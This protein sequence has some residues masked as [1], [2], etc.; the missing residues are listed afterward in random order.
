MPLA[1]WLLCMAMASTTSACSSSTRNVPQVDFALPRRHSFC[2]R[3]LIKFLSG[4]RNPNRVNNTQSFRPVVAWVWL[5]LFAFV[6]AFLGGSSR[7]DIG[8]ITPLRPLAALFLIPALYYIRLTDLRQAKA[9]VALFALFAIWMLLQLIPV[10]A[11]IWHVLPGRDAVVNLDQLL[12]IEETWRPISMVPSRGWNALASLIVPLTALLLALSMRANARMLLLLVAVL[13]LADAALGLL[14]VIGGRNSFLYFYAIT[15]RGSPVGI[16]ANENHSAVF[17]AIALLVIAYLGVT[18][19]EVKERLWLRLAYTPSFA[20]VLLAIV[21]SGSRAGIAMGSIALV[22]VCAM[23]WISMAASSQDRKAG[24][25]RIWLASHPKLLL[26]VFVAAIAALLAA[27]IGLDRASG[28]NDVFNQNAFEDLRWSLLPVLRQ[29]AAT[30]WGLGIGFGS[31]EEAYHIFEPTSLLL[32]LYVNQAHN[33]W[34]QLVIEGGLPAVLLLAIALVWVAVSLIRKM[35]APRRDLSQIL[36]FAFAFAII[37]GAS[38]VDY[39]LRAPVFQAVSVWLL[40]SLA[41]SRSNSHLASS[42]L[43]RS[44]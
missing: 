32:P 35:A 14:Q 5:G 30:Y 38:L 15:N 20:I 11:A 37:A 44:E 31:F 2:N 9:L 25:V 19:R 12:G 39:P 6:A 43:V 28:F 8:Q 42:H 10:P 34:L 13:G 40:L 26:A 29:M 23:A 36:M 22:V 17:S 1:F 41:L 4:Q 16:L 24:K 27:F 21:V 7:P 18:S 33:D 3:A